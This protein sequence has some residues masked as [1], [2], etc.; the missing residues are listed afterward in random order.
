VI[1]P[2]T[3]AHICGSKPASQAKIRRSYAPS[4]TSASSQAARSIAQVRR[5]HAALSRSS[6][7]RDVDGADGGRVERLPFGLERSHVVISIRLER[8][9]S[10]PSNGGLNR[11]SRDRC[12][13][14]TGSPFVVGDRSV[15]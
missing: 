12:A 14:R 4:S 9:G 15:W 2:A 8:I 3:T 11:R 6:L 10:G 1:S 7:E 5:L 13:L